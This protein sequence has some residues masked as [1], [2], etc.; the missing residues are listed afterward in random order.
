MNAASSTGNG[1][2]DD[3]ARLDLEHQRVHQHRG[4]HAF[5]RNHQQR[6]A[7][8]APEAAEPVF[9]DEAASL[10]SMS[11]FMCRPARHMWTVRDA[12]SRAATIA[13][14]PSHSAWFRGL[15]EQQ[16]GADAEEDQTPMPQWMAGI[17]PPPRFPEIREADGDDQESF[18]P[19]P[20]RD[21]ECLQ[22]GVSEILVSDVRPVKSA[23]VRV[24]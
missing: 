7:E 9:T 12:T 23:F 15:G 18:D 6:E 2:A 13:R 10:P 24:L 14:I 3:V 17:A 20:E 5:A 4:F 1:A 19:F 21:H 8:H 11:C 22:H 16:A